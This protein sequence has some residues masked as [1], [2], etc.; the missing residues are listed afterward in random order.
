MQ[1]C[2]TDAD[3][4]ILDNADQVGNNCLTYMETVQGVTTCCKIYNKMVQML[5]SKSVRETVGRQHWKDWVCQKNTRLA[6]ARDLAKD[7]GLIRAEVTFYC[8]DN[9]PSD[10]LMEDTLKRITQYVTPS[11]VYC[12][13]FAETWRAYCDVMLHSLVVIGRTREVGLIVY[14]YNEMTKNISGQFVEHWS[15]KERWCLGNLT[16]GSKLPLDVIEICDRSKIISKTGKTKIKDIYVDISDTRFF[17][18]RTDGNADFSTRL[19]SKGVVYSWYEGRKKCF[20][21]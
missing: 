14:T 1:G 21:A 2:A 5:E 11:L 4:T 7:C 16:L 9:V 20:L 15:E 13:P 12:T 18:N 17:E 3:R 19:V 10:S 6:K 8:A